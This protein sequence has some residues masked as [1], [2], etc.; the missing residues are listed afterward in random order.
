MC[1]F[2]MGDNMEYNSKY[3]DLAYNE[4]VKA[5]NNNE[6]PVGC[7]IIKDDKIIASAYNLKEFNKCIIDHAEMICIRNASNI[8]NNWRL[9][10]CDIYITLDPC[11]MCASAIK[12][13]RI[14]NVYCGCSTNEFDNK[15]CNEIFNN[16]D[17]NN[18]V[19]FITDLDSDRCKKLLEDFFNKRRNN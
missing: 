7:V 11:P 19:N 3:M 9:S 14:K 10:D 8:L 4:A 16:I 17:R 12:Q 6:I 15:I 2:F 5:F 13:A 1:T 18:S